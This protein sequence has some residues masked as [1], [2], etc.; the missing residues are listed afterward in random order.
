MLVLMMVLVLL[1]VLLLLVLM[2]LV[3]VSGDGVCDGTYNGN[4]YVPKDGDG[5]NHNNDNN[6]KYTNEDDTED[7]TDCDNGDDKQHDS[8][9]I[10]NDRP[11][12][13]GCEESRRQ[14]HLFTRI[15]DTLA[16][17]GP[18]TGK[19]GGKEDVATRRPVPSI[20]RENNWKSKAY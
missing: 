14:G 10:G 15:E 3:L 19:N 6:Q 2:L 11:S 1:L 20:A 13:S 12:G 7:G 18:R 4:N 16:N 9:D 5:E 17:N 8:R